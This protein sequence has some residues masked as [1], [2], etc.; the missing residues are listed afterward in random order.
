[1]QNPCNCWAQPSHE[2]FQML[3]GNYLIACHVVTG[4]DH[5]VKKA[6]GGLDPRGL[7]AISEAII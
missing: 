6:V 5:K 2:T 3:N 7:Q 4:H 1:M